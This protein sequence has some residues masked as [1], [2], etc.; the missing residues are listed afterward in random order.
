VPMMKQTRELRYA[1]RD[2]VQVLELPYAGNDLSMVLLLPDEIDGLDELQARLTTERLETWT[3]HLHEAEVD[4]F[5]PRFKMTSAF[6]LNDVLKTL[7]MPEAFSDAL[8]DFSGMDGTQFLYIAAV[9]HKAFVDVNEEGTEAAAATAVVMKFRG[10]PA[11]PIVFRANHPFIFLIRDN[12][13]RS[14]LFLGRV[15][16]P[17]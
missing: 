14:I 8:A 6:G 3:S 5:L 16:N 1:R 11:P 10:M 9:L 4:V 2:G 12:V 13:T 7:G 17:K 15:A